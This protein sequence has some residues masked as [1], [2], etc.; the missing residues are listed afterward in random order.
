MKDKGIKRPIR[1]NECKRVK[2]NKELE[3]A[4][5]EYWETGDRT[6]LEIELKKRG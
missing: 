3:L 1:E 5:T 4:R 6:K 2:Y